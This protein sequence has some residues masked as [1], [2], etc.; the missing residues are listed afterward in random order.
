MRKIDVVILTL[1]TIKPIAIRAV[2][3]PCRQDFPPRTNPWMLPGQHHKGGR[4]VPIFLILSEKMNKGFMVLHL[5]SHSAFFILRW[6]V[7]GVR[8]ASDLC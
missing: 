2:A 4:Y 6:T 7:C 3:Y 5:G 1:E 8:M